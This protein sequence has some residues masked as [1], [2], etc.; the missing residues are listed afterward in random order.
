MIIQIH[1]TSHVLSS[2]K[3][4]PL[5][6]KLRYRVVVNDIDRWIPAVMIVDEHDASVISENTWT[7]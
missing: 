2:S 1:G 4:R 6:R 3:S 7:P 5:Y